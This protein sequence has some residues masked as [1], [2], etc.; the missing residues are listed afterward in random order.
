MDRCLLSRN[1]PKSLRASPSE[2]SPS[3]SVS[4]AV[5]AVHELASSP[6]GGS[7]TPD[8]WS[9]PPCAGS[10]KLGLYR[11]LGDEHTVAEISSR[12]VCEKV[13]RG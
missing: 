13:I 8:T 1:G 7:R 12:C 6:A 2:S 11:R 3:S 10:R 9:T 4:L 5:R